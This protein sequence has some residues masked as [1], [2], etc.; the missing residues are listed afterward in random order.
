[1]RLVREGLE[2][3]GASLPLRSGGFPYWA[4]PPASWEGIVEGASALRLTALRLDVPW[5]LHERAPGVLDWGEVHPELALRRVLSLAD[6]RG[7]FVLIRPGPWLGAPLP[8]GG[9]PPRL[10]EV[11]G[12]RAVGPDGG[13]IDVPGPT[14]ARLEREARWWLEQLMEHVRPHLFP[15]GPVAGWVIGDTGPTP[16]LWPGGALD[17]SLQSRSFLAR[18]LAVKY[19]GALPPAD[20]S[21]GIRSMT[22][23]LDRVEAGEVVRR[24]A[25]GWAEQIAPDV[26]G[27]V[28]LTAE[29]TDHPCGS[30]GDPAATRPDGGGLL[31]S[32]PPRG[33]LDYAELRLIGLRAGLLPPPSG[34]SQV[35]GSWP[36]ETGSSELDVATAAGVLAMSGV[37]AIDLRSIVKI[38]GRAG[39][40]APLE[41]LGR[42][43]E[44][45]TRLRDLFRLLDAIDHPTLERRVDC[46]LLANRE[47]ARLRET[48]A[49]DSLT[50]GLASPRVLRLLRIAASDRD[51]DRPEVDHD[52]VFDALSD[53]LRGAGIAFGVSDTSIDR[54]ALEAARTI[55]LVSFDRMGRAL[56]QRLFE[57]V[58]RGGTLVLGPRLPT[59][60]WA[61]GPL[62]LG[63]APRVKDRS[64]RLRL[65]DLE[66]EDA[67]LFSSG[68]P[69]VEVAEG[70]LAS[71]V[72]VESGRLIRFGFRPPFDALG[73]S[74]EAIAWLLTRLADGAGIGPCY[75]ASDPRVETEL[76]EGPARRFLFLANPTRVDRPVTVAL[77]PGE[78]LREVRGRAEHIRAGQRFVVPAST[79]LVRE[80][81]PL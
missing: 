3:D 56:A 63:A 31:L 54:E 32:V 44:T 37:R 34:V 77:D 67:E 18:Y 64:P 48:R 50:P 40:H 61:G 58:G 15:H 20:E 79:V 47:V 1:V 46:L 24:L 17:Y 38:P 13:E 80:L 78:A 22:H 72:P 74:P 7:L 12:V 42:P 16:A 66:L 10:L 71:A 41:P 73:R 25:L 55:F 60:D 75:P 59:R 19:G 29:V 76:F 30:G 51:G 4:L 27:A 14:S 6:A 36:I 33:T 53:G 65:R 39:R 69:I 23:A 9:I 35:P 43:D 57:W 49:A 52:I 70:V 11:E 45:G 2:V 28:P 81:V 8:H 5:E 21:T 62:G 26:R 68:E